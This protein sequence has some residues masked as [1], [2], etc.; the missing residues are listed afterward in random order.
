M[1]HPF[2]LLVFLVALLVG[3]TYMVSGSILRSSMEFRSPEEA[4]WA[5][6]IRALGG[7]E[8]YAL[9]V[10]KVRPLTE[11]EKHLAAHA[12]GAALYRVLGVPGLSVCDER[13]G[14]GCFHEF[15]GYAIAELGIDSVIMLNEACSSVLKSS[16]ISCQ[17]AIGH[18]V[19]AYFGYEREHLEQALTLCKELPYDDSISGCFGGAFMEYNMRTMLGRDASIRERTQ[20]AAALC[21]SVDALYQSGCFYWISQWWRAA[22]FGES[23]DEETFARLGALCDES[24]PTRELHEVCY[25]GIGLITPQATAYDPERTRELC[26]AASGLHADQLAC[27]SNASNIIRMALGIAPGESVCESLE[28]EMYSYCLSY[29]RNEANLLRPLAIPSAL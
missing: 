27:V 7:K 5:R 29:A 25:R 12:F 13:Y 22:F 21:N 3:A 18:G 1:K 8:A 6:Y 16:W 28:G 20:D 24:T 11:P 2:L 26:L 14:Y 15:M 9:F 10:E 23:S 19:Q 4:Q 17:H